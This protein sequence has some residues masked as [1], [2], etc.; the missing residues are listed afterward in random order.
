MSATGFQFKCTECDRVTDI[1]GDAPMVCPDC[2]AVG[3]PLDPTNVSRVAHEGPSAR[4]AT[5]LDLLETNTITI[6]VSVT[7]DGFYANATLNALNFICTVVQPSLDQ[8]LASVMPTVRSYV[9]RIQEGTQTASPS[10]APLDQPLIDDWIGDSFAGEDEGEDDDPQ[11]ATCGVYR[12]EHT[13]CGCAD[14]FI[15]AEAWAREKEAIQ[16]QV[17]R[18]YDE[19]RNYDPEDD[20]DLDDYDPQSI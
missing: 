9:Q 20:F 18:E 16:E 3:K 11:C 15:T 5:L 7:P 13:L 8:A 10:G 4:I 12:S 14:G 2:V 1:F 19:G 17:N 6:T